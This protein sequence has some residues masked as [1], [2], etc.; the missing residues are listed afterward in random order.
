MIPGDVKPKAL[1]LEVSPHLPGAWHLDG[2]IAGL[3][4]MT[5]ITETLFYGRHWYVVRA[6]TARNHKSYIYIGLN[7]QPFTCN[8]VTSQSDWNITN[9]T[10][11]N[12]N[13]SINQS[14]LRNHGETINQLINLLNHG[15]TINQ[16]FNLLN[17]E[18]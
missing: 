7:L 15:E 8:L 17:Y 3:S 4:D 10:K 1:I 18:Y 16:S 6:L 14:T 11:S 12:N 2:R 9:R 5:L 13:Q